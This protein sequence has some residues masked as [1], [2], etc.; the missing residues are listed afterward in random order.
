[1]I[2]IPQEIK[3]EPI[4][5]SKNEEA[6]WIQKIKG[7]FEDPKSK[8]LK[9]KQYRVVKFLSNVILLSEGKAFL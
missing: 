9:V 6:S 3:Q 8:D 7:K 4:A 2:Q 1:M 5:L